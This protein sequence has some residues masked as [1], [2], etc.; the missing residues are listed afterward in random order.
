MTLRP[1]GDGKWEVGT[2][3]GYFVFPSFWSAVKFI[4]QTT[5]GV[6]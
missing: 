1:I 6:W 3:Y 2:Y 5:L 4:V